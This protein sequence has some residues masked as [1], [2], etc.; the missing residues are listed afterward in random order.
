MTASRATPAAAT[1]CPTGSFWN[2]CCAASTRAQP[3]PCSGSARRSTSTA[4]G[5]GRS[6]SPCWDLAGRAAG[7]PRLAAARRQRTAARGLRLDRRAGGPDGARAPRGG[8]ARPRPA[9]AQDPLPPPRLARRR[10]GG[11]GRAGGGRRRDGDHGRREPGLAD[12]RRPR[13]A[14]ELDTARACA[15]RSSRSA[16]T[17]WRSRCPR[18]DVD[19]YAPWP[20]STGMPIAAGRDG[21]AGA[22]GARP[23][24][25][26]GVAV[27]QCDVA[28]LRRHRRLPA[29]RRPRPRA[30]SQLVAAHLVERVRAGREP[31]CGLRASHHGY[32][33]VPYDPPA[34]SAERRDWMLPLVSRSR[35]RHDRAPA[36]AGARRRAGSGC[37]RAMA[38]GMRTRAAVLR[39]MGSPLTVEQLELAPPGPGEVLVRVAAAGVCHSDVH[40]ADGHLGSEPQ[41]IVLGHEGAGTVEAVG[42]GVAHVAPGDRV[43][44]ASCPPA[45]PARLPGRPRQPLRAGRRAQQP[46]GA[47]RRHHAPLVPRRRARQALPQRR[48]LRRARRRARRRGGAAAGGAAAVAGGAGRL[49]RRHRPGR[50]AQRG[51]RTARRERRRDRLRRRRPAGRSRAPGWP[52][53]PAMVAVDRDPGKAGARAAAAAPPTWCWR[54]RPTTPLARVRELCATAAPTTRSRWWARPETIRQ[55]FDMIRPGGTAVVVGIAAQ[56]GRGGVAGPRLPRATRRSRAASTARAI[57]PPRCRS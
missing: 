42:A 35:R 53:P 4:A 47:G 5:P 55:A 45:A 41:P 2:G 23:A 28:V 31:A 15:R 33:E 54:R 34:W 9:R 7:V 25:R 29:D 18:A 20:A 40:L 56:R 49:Q 6:R 57:R 16:S 1:A 22:R 24:L 46:R 38:G 37:A 8:A 30:G 17:G 32:V 12:A 51:P 50:G 13:A 36:R 3:I 48:L 19:G 43:A 27:I 14:W 21:A 44:S 39:E 26:G 52:G 11:R 10:A